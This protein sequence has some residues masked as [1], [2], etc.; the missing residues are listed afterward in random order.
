M[1]SAVVLRKKGVFVS[2]GILLVLRVSA[3]WFF[4]GDGARN[5]MCKGNNLP[6]SFARLSDETAFPFLKS[7][8]LFSQLEKRHDSTEHQSAITR[9]PDARSCL[10]DSEGKK[11]IPSLTR[12]DWDKIR[13][14]QDAEV[15]LFR[16]LSSIRS[17]KGSQKWLESQGLSIGKTQDRSFFSNAPFEEKEEFGKQI[18]ANC[19]RLRNVA[20]DLRAI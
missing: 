16:I 15:C 1:L 17:F 20:Q 2:V 18:S 8:V 10:V 6:V 11:Q 4:I 9:F 13:V 5:L 7:G 14:T 19:R 12:F 3:Y